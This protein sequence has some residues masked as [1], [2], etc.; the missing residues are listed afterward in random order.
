MAM[1]VPRAAV[2]AE[3]IKEVLDTPS[4]VIRR[5]RA[6]S[7]RSRPPGSLEL[8]DVGFDY[9]GAEAP[10]LHRHL[11]AGLARPDHGHHRQHRRGQD[12]AAQPG[13]PPVR[14]HR[15]ARCSSTASTSATSSPRR[16]GTA[17]AWCRR[18][19]TSSPARSP[20]TCAT[21]N[22]DATDDEL[23]AAL[24]IAQAA[25][26]VSAMPGGLDAPI[27]QGGT[28]VSGG[29]RQRL[30]IARALVRKP[31]IYLFDDSFSALDLAT[32]ARLRAALAPS[33]PTPTVLIVAQRV[34]T[35]IERRPD[36]RAGGRRSGRARHPRRAARDLPDLPGDRRVPDERRGGGVSERRRRRPR[37]ATA[38]GRRDSARTAA[39]SG[40]NGAAP[41]EVDRGRASPHRS[42]RAP[43]RRR[44]VPAS[45]PR[46]SA[47]RPAACW[48]AMGP[49]RQW[50]LCRA[51]LRRRQ[52]HPVGARP[53]DPRPR[54]RHHRARASSA[55]RA[56]TSRSSAHVL[57]RRR[58]PS[59]SSLGVAR[60]G[61]SRYTLA[62]VVQR[63]MYRLRAR[64]R[65]QAQ[66]AAAALRRQP[67][68]RRPAQPG[69]QRHR[70]HRPEPP[71]DAEPD[72]RRRSSR[73]SASSS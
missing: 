73:S 36:P 55:R 30:A 51:R 21:A 7:P 47:A 20:A 50:A 61:C 41:A 2:C 16:C 1:M 67:A 44:P 49:E 28:N 9:P 24:E 65:G 45:G 19:R 8:R 64:R 12:D 40:A 35:I 52:R 26:F 58:W 46:T 69:H 63:T 72:A 4:S 5:R 39:P 66:P 37:T 29:Q 70:Q 33:P 43:R 6:R 53:E 18:S 13:P 15:R 23:W 62:G 38:T 57:A 25:D 60:P 56:S 48:P 10:V 17:S 32:D 27:A 71:A 34:S 68:P 11:A 3:R 31:E 22:P 54:H 14:R 42:R 59:T